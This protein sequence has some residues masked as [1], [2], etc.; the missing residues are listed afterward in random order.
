MKI[1]N[2][3]DL[4]AGLVVVVIASAVLVLGRP[5][6]T[7]SATEMGPGWFPGRVAWL[8]LAAGAFLI[9]RSLRGASTR[10][11]PFRLRPLIAVVAAVLVFALGINRFGLLLTA[12]P[13]L[14]IASVA[15]AGSSLRGRLIAALVITLL[16]AG[17]FVGAL[18]LT[19]PLLPN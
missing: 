13:T 16:A 11:P 4:G 5:L 17:V 8:A 6:S 18:G 7:G 1:R 12:P 15:V 19:I 2:P 14:L 10:L 9:L 3:A